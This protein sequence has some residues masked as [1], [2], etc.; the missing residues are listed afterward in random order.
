[1]LMQCSYRSFR[2]AFLGFLQV[3]HL[4][5]EKLDAFSHAVVVMPKTAATVSFLMSEIF[6]IFQRI[7]RLVITWSLL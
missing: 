6:V 5:W 7:T 4:D 3:V 2:C 1:M